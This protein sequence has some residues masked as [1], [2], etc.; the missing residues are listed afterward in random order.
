VVQIHSP[1][2]SSQMLD[3]QLGYRV[4]LLRQAFPNWFPLIVY[5]I[6]R[7]ASDH[8]GSY[9]NYGEAEEQPD[10]F[11]GTDPACGCC[12]HGRCYREPLDHRQGRSLFTRG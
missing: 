1:R 4:F 9:S 8:R 5:T 3:S 6:T 12:K 10:R 7:Q 2:L 11:A